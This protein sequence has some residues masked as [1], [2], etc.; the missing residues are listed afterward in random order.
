MNNKSL[1]EKRETAVKSKTVLI[2]SVVIVVA[3]T[4]WGAFFTE[5]CAAAINVVNDFLCHELGWLYLLMAGFFVFFGLFIAFSKYGKIKLGKDE[6]KPDYGNF[7]WFAL[8]F[9]GGIGIGL[10]FWGVAEPM[11]HIQSNPLYATTDIDVARNAIRIAFMHEG[12]HCWAMFAVVGAALGYA[13]HRKGLPC[14]ISSGFYPLI[15][16]KVYGP[17]GKVIDIIAVFATVF[18]ISTSLGLGALQ[19]SGGLNYIYG[20]GIDPY[21]TCIVI[22]IITALFTLATVSGLEKMMSKVVNAKVYL[23]IVFMVFLLV[24]G[25][26][27]YIMQTMTDVFGAYVSTFIR[28]TFW[29]GNPEWLGGGWTVFYWAWW[30]AW[31]PFCGQFFARVSKGRTLKEMLLAG[32]LLPAGFSFLWMIIYGGAGININ[33]LTGGL[34]MQAT[35]NDYTTALYSLL[36]QLPLYP[37][38]APLALILVVLCFVGAADS[39]TFVLPMLTLGGEMNPSKKSR[40]FWGIAQGA[41]TVAIILAGGQAA[42]KALQTASVV[43][44]LPFMFVMFGLCIGLYW[45]LKTELDPSLKGR[46]LFRKAPKAAVVEEEVKT[47]AE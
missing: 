10:V 38:M 13:Q 6:D 23:A 2:V 9:G 4:I 24:F 28:Q 5:S 18:G 27:V 44:A 32:T 20:M 11:F 17:I 25:G 22:G 12:I 42:L 26:F 36:Q 37:V 45:A 21:K 41:V 34:I 16:D 14:L 1:A 29:L 7:Q 43:A 30:M 46:F 39:A 33:N 35:N 8:L 3:F 47:T 15:G 31:S 19:I 40:A